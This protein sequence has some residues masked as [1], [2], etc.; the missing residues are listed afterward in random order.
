MFGNNVVATLLSFIFLI[1]ISIVT[2]DYVKK[3]RKKDATIFKNFKSTRDS[4][5]SKYRGYFHGKI[6]TT[7]FASCRCK[8]L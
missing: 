1:S 3:K 4:T 6:V 2:N 7:G 5:V 8:I